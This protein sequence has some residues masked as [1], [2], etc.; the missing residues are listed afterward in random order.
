MA[1]S[2]LIGL[3]LAAA[4]GPPLPAAGPGS[5]D[6]AGVRLGMAPESVRRSLTRSGYGIGRET[7]LESYARQVAARIEALRGRVGPSAF[8]AVAAIEAVGPSGERVAV[9]FGQWPDGPHVVEVAL[10]VDPNRQTQDA[11]RAQA[12]GRFGPPTMHVLGGWRWCGA[13][14]RR[15]GPMADPELPTL[16][17]DYQARTLTLKI[18]GEALQQ[19]R[20]LVE[21]DARRAVPLRHGSAF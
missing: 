19:R 7:R 16:D 14:E 10:T 13:G 20:A 11:F 6:L 1:S 3:A 8:E 17:A 4:S 21:A 9:T 5:F 15:C 18:G 12:E 2:F